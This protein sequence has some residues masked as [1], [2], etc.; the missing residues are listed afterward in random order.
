[1]AAEDFDGVIDVA[2]DWDIAIP[3]LSNRARAMGGPNGAM[4]AQAR[5]IAAKLGST[6]NLASRLEED[7]SSF[8]PS[9]YGAIGDGLNDDTLALEAAFLHSSLTGLSVYLKDGNAY[10]FSKLSIPANVSI[11]GQG[12]L[13]SDSSLTGKTDS[14]T[15]AGNFKA[16]TLH[17]SSDGLDTNENMILFSGDYVDI[18]GLICESDVERAGP[19]GVV[20]RGSHVRVGSLKTLN[21]PRPFAVQRAAAG[22]PQTDIHIGSVDIT[23]Y[24]RGIS[25]LNCEDWSVGTYRMRGRDSRASKVPGNNG[26]LLASCRRFSVATGIIE[27]SGEHAVRIGGNEGWGGNTSDFTF[28]VVTVLRSGGCAF[29]INPDVG[30][31]TSNGEIEGVVGIDIGEG[32]T[33][34]NS[35]VVRLT[36][37]DNI[38]IGYVHARRRNQELGPT[39]AVLLSN[40]QDLSI[41]HVFGQKVTGRMIEI[42]SDTDSNNGNVDG[43]YIGSVSGSMSG[44]RC[45]IGIHYPVSGK[46][47]GNIF[48]Q[49]KN[50]TGYTNMLMDVTAGSVAV[51]PVV[52]SGRIANAALPLTAGAS[53]ENYILDIAYGNQS[54]RGEAS[55]EVRKYGFGLQ[56]KAFDPLT[57]AENPGDFFAMTSRGTPGLNAYG[58]SYVFSRVGSTRRGAAIAAKQST[59]DDKKVGIAFLVGD[60]NTVSNESVLERMFLGHDG[61]LHLPNLKVFASDSAAGTGGI[62]SGGLYAT[63]TGEVRRKL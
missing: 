1:M 52:I 56:G 11:V 13:R 54:F 15:V 26:F 6:Y 34:G 51:A 62:P 58:G 18:G 25:F 57:G 14:I 48:I 24:I 44:A 21:N 63:S 20:V 42:S 45:A 28:G 7:A 30:E 61:T 31:I 2:P 50:I 8:S 53:S 29:K 27:D 5:A 41:D 35:E 55:Q 9:R 12:I 59:T 19:A 37:Y 43:V 46:T 32:T 4:N 33:L 38:H 40:G 47:I 36:R 17:V 16:E 10:R 49:V 3:Q 39:R 23:G 60:S 22:E